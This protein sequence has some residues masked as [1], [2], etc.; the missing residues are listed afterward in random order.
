LEYEIIGEFLADL[1]KEFG[2]R[3]D[4]TMKVAKL[5]KVEQG[6]RTMKEFVQKFKRVARDSEYEGRLLIEEFKRG[7]NGVIR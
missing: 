6:N 3:D 7:I 2:R 5:K 4:E 1:K